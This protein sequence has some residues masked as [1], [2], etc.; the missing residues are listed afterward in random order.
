MIQLRILRHILLPFLVHYGKL[1]KS[2]LDRNLLLFVVI[3]KSRQRHKNEPGIIQE[4][5]FLEEEYINCPNE[6]IKLKL[7]GTF[8]KLNLCYECKL[9]GIIIRSRVRWVE[10]GEKSTRYF[11]NLESRRKLSHSINKIMEKDGIVITDSNQILKKDIAFYC[12]LYRRD[13]NV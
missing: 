12:N 3:I 5:S 4:I 7:D 2:I 9:M 13:C 1:L 8:Y 11:L 10:N 6:N